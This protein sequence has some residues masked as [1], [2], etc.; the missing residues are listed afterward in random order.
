MRFSTKSDGS[1]SAS[2]PELRTT[3]RNARAP[4]H[5]LFRYNGYVRDFPSYLLSMKERTVIKKD[6]VQPT[7][8]TPPPENT[9]RAKDIFVTYFFFVYLPLGVHISFIIIKITATCIFW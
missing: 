9:G 4:C 8:C 2:S 6:T 5:L 7:V 3:P 1:L